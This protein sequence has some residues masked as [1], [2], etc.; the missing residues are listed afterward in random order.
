M[1]KIK[2]FKMEDEAGINQALSEFPISKGAAV[3]VSNGHLN[4]PIE[5]GEEA[6]VAVRIIRVKELIHAEYAAAEVHNQGKREQEVK[7]A[8]V[9]SQMGEIEEKVK[10]LEKS[11]HSEDKNSKMGYEQSKA[12]KTEIKEL[13]SILSDLH[14]VLNQTKSSIIQRTAELTE[15]MTTIAVLNERLNHLENPE[16]VND[17]EE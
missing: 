13:N 8:G 16:K 6:P 12:I 17:D 15:S 5:D 14:N 10:G 3:F 7:R 1:L 9:E 11:L 2:S 4:I